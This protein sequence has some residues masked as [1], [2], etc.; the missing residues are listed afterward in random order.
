MEFFLKRIFAKGLQNRF[1]EMLLISS[2]VF[3]AEVEHCS[4]MN[5]QKNLLT[6]LNYLVPTYF[7][8]YCYVTISN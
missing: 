4:H 3:V 1:L 2:C 6:S 7:E 8:S 5:S